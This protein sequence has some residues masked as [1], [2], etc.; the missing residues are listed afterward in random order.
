MTDPRTMKDLTFTANLHVPTNPCPTFSLLKEGMYFQDFGDNL[1]K[2]AYGLP[3]VDLTE[4]NSFLVP[5]PLLPLPLDFV[6]GEWQSLVCLG[7]PKPGA[8]APLHP[9]Y[10][11]IIRKTFQTQ[12]F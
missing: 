11:Q 7:H 12:T 8:L 2:L 5:L 4:I 9:S 1:E 6:K 3:G 10:K